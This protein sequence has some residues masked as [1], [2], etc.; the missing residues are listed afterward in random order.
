[1]DPTACLLRIGKPDRINIDVRIAIGDLVEW[2]NRGG[3]APDWKVSK[4]GTSR[5]RRYNRA[6]YERTL[7]A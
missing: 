6:L 1:M 2:L 5:F 7:A 4:R 3:F